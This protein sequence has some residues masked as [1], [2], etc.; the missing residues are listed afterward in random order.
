MRSVALLLVLSALILA[1]TSFN[2]SNYA[3]VIYKDVKGHIHGQLVPR[4]QLTKFVMTI[5][6]EGYNL[7]KVDHFYKVQVLNPKLS[8]Q[9]VPPNTPWYTQMV[10]NEGIAW[11]VDKYHL[12]AAEGLE[13]L[14]EHGIVPNV[15]VAVIDTGVANVTPLAGKVDYSE[16]YASTALVDNLAYLGLCN[17]TGTVDLGGLQV[18]D[19]I[20]GLNYTFPQGAYAKYC[21][22]A[23]PANVDGYNSTVVFIQFADPRMDIVGH[24]TFVSSQIVASVN[25]PLVNNGNSTYTNVLLGV[26]P[27]ITVVPIKADYIAI[28][29]VNVTGCQDFSACVQNT[30]VDKRIMEAGIFDDFSLADAANY[31]ANLA[32]NDPHLKAVNMSLGGYDDEYD[33]PSDCQWIIDPM[34]SAGLY[35]VAAAGNDG[36]NLDQINSDYGFYEFPAQC[37]GVIAVSALDGRNMITFFSNYGSS[38]TFGAPGHHNVGIYWSQSILGQLMGEL[39]KE[40]LTLYGEPVFPLYNATTYYVTEGSGTSYAA[41]LVSGAVALLSSLTPNPVDVLKQTA[42]KLYGNTP[43]PYVGYGEPDV[44]AAVKMLFY[45]PHNEESTSTTTVTTTVYEGAHIAGPFL[46]PFFLSGLKKRRKKK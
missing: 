1:A 40:Y 31:V 28:A 34:T 27:N 30:T 42:K 37:P 36:Y 33:F 6:A 44:G 4:S 38:I 46:I 14:D 9:D 21:I 41:P 3:I 20:D 15:K 13:I 23:I 8:V 17:A 24:G 43:N 16:G 12:N 25:L 5:K 35:V 26:H 2:I 39:Y 10:G 22:F 11:Q 7:I 45:K 18:E 29:F 19:P 32:F